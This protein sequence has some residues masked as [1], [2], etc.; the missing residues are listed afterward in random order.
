MEKNT[1][2]I[3]VLGYNKNRALQH[4]KQETKMITPAEVQE[5][6]TQPDFLHTLL[7]IWK[8]LE[9]GDEVQIKISRDRIICQSIVHSDELKRG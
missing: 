3:F 4:N 2:L 7:E 9:E 6:T 5:L 8:R 1:R